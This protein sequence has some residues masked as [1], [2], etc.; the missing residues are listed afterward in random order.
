MM[1]ALLVGI[2]V[3]FVL[4]IPP[5]PIAMACNQGLVG[6]HG[7]AWPWCSGPRRSIRSMRC[8]PHVPHPRW[9][10]RSGVW[11]CPTRGEWSGYVSRRRVSLFAQQHQ[12]TDEC[13]QRAR[14]VIRP[15]PPAARP[16]M[17]PTTAPAIPGTIIMIHPPGSRPA[18]GI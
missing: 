3:G 18:S 12:G 17:P 8:W 4:A 7:R 10:G 14:G 16:S 11:S 9:W 15:V 13:H 2:V 6:R 5:G 1:T